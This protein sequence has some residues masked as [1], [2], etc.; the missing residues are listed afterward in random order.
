MNIQLF[1]KAV[2]SSLYLHNLRAT[3]LKFV[4]DLGCMHMPT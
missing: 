1:F 3:T 2:E 4:H